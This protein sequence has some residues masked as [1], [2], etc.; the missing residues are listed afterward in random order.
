MKLKIKVIGIILFLLIIGKSVWGQ[1]QKEPALPAK[2]TLTYASFGS[3]DVI[4]FTPLAGAASYSGE[5]FYVLG[6]TYLKPLNP[7][8]YLETGLEF[9]HHNLVV[10]A[11]LPPNVDAIPYTTEVLLLGAP[12]GARLQLSRHFFAQAGL[13]LDLDLSDSA[14]I[15]SQTGLGTTAG[16]GFNF[17]L[18]AGTAAFLNPY[19]KLHGLLPFAGENYP[20]RLVESGF[21]IGISFAVSHK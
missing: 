18:S 7:R 13:I 19:L 6:V 15:D 12:I 21:K 8:F 4:R 10:K 17:D 16:L 14:S 1:S 2:V 9:S 11:N 5:G 3:N 20:Q